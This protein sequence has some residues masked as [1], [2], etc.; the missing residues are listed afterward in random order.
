MGHRHLAVHRR[1]S[2]L[3]FQALL[4]VGLQRPFPHPDLA[5]PLH[6]YRHLAESR[7]LAEPLHPYRHLAE[8]LHPYRHLAEPLY[9]YRHLAELLHPQERLVG[10]R[11]PSVLL[12][13][14]LHLEEAQHPRRFL[15]KVFLLRG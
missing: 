11:R 12:F 7:H 10:H 4:L 15:I 2:V 3:F 5:E 1:P 13:Q 14:M 9:P 6:P 8:P